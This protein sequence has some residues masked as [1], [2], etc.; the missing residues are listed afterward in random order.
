LPLLVPLSRARAIPVMMRSFRIDHL[1]KHACD[2]KH[3]LAH[4]G[5]GVQ[6]L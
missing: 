3:A 1:G 5:R 2:L 6:T 4:R